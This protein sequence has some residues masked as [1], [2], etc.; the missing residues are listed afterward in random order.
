MRVAAIAPAG[1]HSSAEALTLARALERHSEHPVARAILAENIP[2]GEDESGVGAHPSVE[3]GIPNSTPGLGVEGGAPG[4]RV[5]IGR[6]DWAAELAGPPQAAPPPPSDGHCILLA[7]EA[8]PVA[9]FELEDEI[10]PEAANA[11]AALRHL[12]I[13]VELLSGDPSPAA[14]RLAAEVGISKLQSGASPDE[15]V[16]YVRALQQAGAVVAMVGD[17]INDAPVLGQ[18]QVSVA[19]GSGSDLARTSADVVLLGDQLQ[20]LTPALRLARKTRTVI[21]QNLAWALAYNLTV[22]P[23]AV[24][25]N[26]APWAAAIGMSAS[27]LLVV[28]NALRLSRGPDR[29]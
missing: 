13:E 18:A 21:R 1:R 14:A 29:K 17:G 28:T 22:L 15:K 26:V 4:S 3:L 11:V 2:C 5:R 24:T 6:P 8:G 10:R 19:M 16:R 27:S 23:L 7:D 9:W 12:G 25:G 20:L